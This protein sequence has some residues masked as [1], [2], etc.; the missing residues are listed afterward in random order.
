MC[1]SDGNGYIWGDFM[2]SEE[3][4]PSIHI[5]IM[6]NILDEFIVDLCRTS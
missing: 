5:I 3:W 6:P 4:K 1:C 2:E